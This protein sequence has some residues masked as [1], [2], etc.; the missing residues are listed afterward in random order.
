[1]L[2]RSFS[3]VNGLIQPLLFIGWSLNSE[4]FFYVALTIG[5]LL[6]R[7]RATWFGSAIVVAVIFGCM[8]FAAVSDPA[9]FY[10]NAINIEF[11]L[12]ILSY[13]AAKH[14]S[15]SAA[16]RMR[17][18]ALFLVCF[19]AILL[20]VIQGVLPPIQNYFYGTRVLTLGIPAFLLVTSVSLLSQAGWDA[21]LAWLILIGDASYILYLVHPYCEYLLDRLFAHQH[22]WLKRESATG[23]FLGAAFSLVLALLIHVYAERPL[24]KFLTHHFGGKRKSTEFAPAK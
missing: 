6:S 21:R 7:R 5:L 2:F 12:G 10:S 16:R 9:R 15:D 22:P 4:M 24:V 17:F 19:S 23:A 13:Y 11:L 3:K 18:V 1:M 14:T 8:P 20:I